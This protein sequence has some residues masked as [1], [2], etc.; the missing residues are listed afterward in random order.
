MRRSPRERGLETPS[1]FCYRP[2]LPSPTCACC[3]KDRKQVMFVPPDLKPGR[4]RARV[5]TKKMCS[6]DGGDFQ[7]CTASKFKFGKGW[8]RET[9]NFFLLIRRP[10]TSKGGVGGQGERSRQGN[11]HGVATPEACGRILCDTQRAVELV[12]GRARVR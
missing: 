11:S 6:Q 7:T 12:P 9:I 2:A 4:E 1:F 10:V 5:Y 3:A 8:A